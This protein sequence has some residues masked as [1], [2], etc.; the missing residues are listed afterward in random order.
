MSSPNLKYALQELHKELPDLTII[1][2]NSPDYETSIERWFFLSARQAGAVVLPTS[3]SEI[4]TILK[5]PQKHSLPIAVEGGGHGLR[6]ESSS[7]GGVVIDLTKLKGVRVE[8]S[9]IIASGGVL[10]SEVYTETGKF[11]LAAV[12]VSPRSPCCRVMSREMRFGLGRR[13]FR[14]VL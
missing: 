10:W 8:G 11:G 9:K 6:G 3:A 13:S 2:P 4:S 5:L 7:D 12:L 14:E 1:T